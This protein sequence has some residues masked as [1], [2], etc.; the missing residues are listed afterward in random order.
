MERSVQLL[1]AH[2]TQK[3]KAVMPSPVSIVLAAVVLQ[4][5][6]GT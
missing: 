3:D 5:D 4:T 6:S 1:P 2:M